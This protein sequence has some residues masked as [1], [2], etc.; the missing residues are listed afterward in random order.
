MLKKKRLL[1]AKIETTIGTAISLAGADGAMNVYDPMIQ[2]N[3]EQAKRPRQGSFGNRKSISKQRGGTATFRTEV[4]GDGAGGVPLWAS[5]L[6]PACGWVDSAG[7]FS[8]TTE[9]PG[10]NVKTIT[11]GCYQD[12]MFKQLFGAAGTFKLIFEAGSPVSIEWTFQGIFDEPDDVTILSPTYP[13]ITPPRFAS[14]TFTIGGS[15]PGC[16]ESLEV[17]AGNEVALRS[18]PGT[19]SGIKSGIVTDRKVNGTMNPESRLIATEDV[20]GKWIAGTEEALVIELD[21][22]TDLISFDAPKLQRQNVQEGERAGIQTDEISFDC[23]G[24]AGDD[25]FTITFEASS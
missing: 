7:V 17:D 9:S 15:S 14:N 22:G 8:P 25:E 4:Y 19:V 5:V 13:A 1:A 10:T 24:N 16:I 2:A 3:I 23:N 18:C 21:D 11:I 12:G 6:L 20:F